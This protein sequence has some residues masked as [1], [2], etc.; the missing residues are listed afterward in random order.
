MRS[1]FFIPEREITMNNMWSLPRGEMIRINSKQELIT[2][3]Q[4]FGFNELTLSKFG[5]K[6]ADPSEVEF[7]HPK[8]QFPAI[9]APQLD[10]NGMLISLKPPAGFEIRQF[11]SESAIELDDRYRFPC[12]IYAWIEVSHSRVGKSSIEIWEVKP[13]GEITTL[14]DL[15][16][17]ELKYG[18]KAEDSLKDALEYQKVINGRN[19]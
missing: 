16:L 19:A 15:Q 3:I 5:I 1:L 7:V 2:L 14:L 4:K 6:I 13:L 9:E 8:L 18:A 10:K 12:V 11:K 17:S